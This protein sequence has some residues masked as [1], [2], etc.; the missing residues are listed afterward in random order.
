VTGLVP[1]ASEGTA[2]PRVTLTTSAEA[3]TEP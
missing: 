1:R 2:I 3:G